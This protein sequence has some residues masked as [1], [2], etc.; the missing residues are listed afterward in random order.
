MALKLES[1]KLIAYGLSDAGLVRQNNED[2]WGS[3]PQHH[4]F[5]LAD[6]MGGHQSGEVAAKEAVHF[7][8]TYLH[9]ILDQAQVLTLDVDDV[10]KIVR[11][12]IV[13]TNRDVF[14][15]GL[16]HE[17]L[18]GMGTTLC[19]LYFHDDYVVHAHVGDSRIYRM[20]HNKIEQLTQ[21]HSLLRELIDKGRLREHEKK[22][23]LYKN[24]ITRAIGTEAEVQPS[25]NI[26]MIHAGDMYLLCSDGL[27]DPLSREELELLLNQPLT[28]EEKVRSLIHAAKRKGG[29]DNI[30]VVLIEVVAEHA[31]GQNR[32][33]HI[34]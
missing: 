17:L 29:Y 33:E 21:D 16:S 24:I 28:V 23:F 1:L 22:D 8:C 32:E 11:D 18:K 6:G 7:L 25:V 12:A 9:K 19:C 20:R 15:L 3:L 31:Q 30:T 13:E 5:V 4:L 27:S 34:S 2:V 14:D 26:S 10:M